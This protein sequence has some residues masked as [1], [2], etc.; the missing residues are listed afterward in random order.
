MTT[1]VARTKAKE[2]RQGSPIK[3]ILSELYVPLWPPDFLNWFYW[4]IGIVG[5]VINAGRLLDHR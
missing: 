1:P 2:H 3:R 4:I 5:A